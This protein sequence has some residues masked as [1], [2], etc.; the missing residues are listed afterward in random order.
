[1]TDG[2]L[3]TESQLHAFVDKQLD[4][5]ERAQILEAIRK[6]P[7]LALLV[8]DIQR[9][10]ELLSLAYHHCT[11]PEH[12][13]KRTPKPYWSTVI[14][15]SV[16]LAI[17]AIFGFI[18]S[19]HTFKQAPPEAPHTAFGTIQN[20]DFAHS[21]HHKVMIHV[22][23]KNT[24]TLKQALDKAE[25]ILR[26]ARDYKKSVK[27]AIVANAE[28]L[29]LLREGS[30][31]SARIKKLAQE[32]NNLQFK[33]CGI[34][35]ETARLKEGHIPTLLPEALKVPNAL[36]EILDKIKNGWIYLKT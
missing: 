11:V 17:S 36:G 35:M 4:Q 31:F 23:S 27:L 32:Y 22:S 5:S 28:G 20:F 30:S 3:F 16:F 1:M 10:K 26:Y 33:A 2:Q 12:V 18:F 6:D 15:A 13:K 9:D 14:A 21:N 19:S 34:A 29:E 8:S 25:R 7:E 24:T